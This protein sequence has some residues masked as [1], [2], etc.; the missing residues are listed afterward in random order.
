MTTKKEY[1]KRKNKLL[2]NARRTEERKNPAYS[3]DAKD[4]HKNFRV[5]ADFLDV[6]P[7]LVATVYFM[8]HVTSLM[9]YAKSDDIHQEEKIDGRFEDALNYLKIM[10][11]LHKE[12]TEGQVPS[13][14]SKENESQNNTRY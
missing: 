1:Q 14:S 3:G 8:K 13:S 11:S 4:V 10:Y 7:I 9:S 12:R 2:K 6:D 5:I